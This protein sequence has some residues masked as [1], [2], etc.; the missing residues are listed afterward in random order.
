MFDADHRPRPDTVTRL[1]GHFEDPPS[2]RSRDG[3]SSAIADNSLI[4]RL[5]AI[6]YLA[7]YLVNEYG[8]QSFFRLPAYGGANCAV[9]TSSLRAMGGWNPESVTEDTDL[10]CD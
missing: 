6:D 1:A 8:R 2:A 4:S 10:T 3:A 7:G 5:V 9:R